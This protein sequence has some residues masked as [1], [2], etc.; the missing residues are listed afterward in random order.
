MVICANSDWIKLFVD[1][2]AILDFKVTLINLLF[3]FVTSKF[4]WYLLSKFLV[5]LVSLLIAI[6]GSKTVIWFIE[7]LLLLFILSSAKKCAFGSDEQATII[8]IKETLARI[9]SVANNP[10]FLLFFL[11]SLSQTFRKLKMIKN[12]N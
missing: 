10:I 2:L 4:S 6:L 9:D 5:N 1:V 3:A 8:G 12:L 7:L 11:V